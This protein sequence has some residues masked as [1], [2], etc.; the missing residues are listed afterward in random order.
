MEEKKTTKAKTKK[1]DA[2]NEQASEAA[3]ATE[4]LNTKLN[5]LLQIAKKKK[6]MLEYQEINNFFGG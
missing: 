2:V 4:L 3:V 6:N 5:E 1:A